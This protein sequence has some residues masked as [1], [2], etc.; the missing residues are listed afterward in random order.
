MPAV[1]YP[2]SFNTDAIVGRPG[3]MSAREYPLSTPDFNRPRQAYRPV[4]IA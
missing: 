3:S 2:Y 4:K 1:A